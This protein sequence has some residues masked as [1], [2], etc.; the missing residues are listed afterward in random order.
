MYT[1][2]DFNAMFGPGAQWDPSK[3]GVLIMGESDI[4]LN[5]ELPQLEAG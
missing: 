4:M 2:G 1:K 5:W 3:I